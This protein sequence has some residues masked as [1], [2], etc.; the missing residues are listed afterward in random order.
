MNGVKLI[1]GFIGLF[2]TG[3]DYSLQFTVTR[4]HAHALHPLLSLGSRTEPDLSYHFLTAAAR[5]D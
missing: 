5:N 3:R 4:A 1:I 2:D